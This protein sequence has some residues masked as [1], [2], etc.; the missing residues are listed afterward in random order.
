V[1]K[2]GRIRV[3]LDGSELAEEALPPAL[4]MPEGIDAEPMLCRVA[5]PAPRTRQLNN[6]P[7]LY[8]ELVTAAYREA[9]H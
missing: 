9:G 6:A 1:F 5:V 7:R 2:Y 8:N 4:A 3:P